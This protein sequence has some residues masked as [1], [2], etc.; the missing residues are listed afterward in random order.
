MSPDAVLEEVRK[1]NIR[2]RGGAGFPTASKW[3]FVRK[4]ASDTKYIVCNGDEGDPALI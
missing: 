3:D 4:A 2:G 1:A